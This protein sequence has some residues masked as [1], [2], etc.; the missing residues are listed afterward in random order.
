MS[1]ACTEWQ[2][3]TISASGTILRITPFMVPTKWSFKPKSVV[4]VTIGRCAKSASRGAK[5]AQTD[6]K[7]IPGRA[8]GQ[9]TEVIALIAG[10]NHYQMKTL[11]E[12]A[13]AQPAT[14]AYRNLKIRL[15]RHRPALCPSLANRGNA[16]ADIQPP[17][18]L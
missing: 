12:N 16:P 10:C 1:N 4:R 14:P 13:G 8:T 18:L 11:N 2:M 9:G 17:L 5:F 15:G 7:V 6:S 3:S